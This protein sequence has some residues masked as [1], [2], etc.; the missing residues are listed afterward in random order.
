[1]R[2]PGFGSDKERGWGDRQSVARDYIHQVRA[3]LGESR[4][5]PDLANLAGRKTP[6]DAA[7]LTQFLYS[8]IVPGGKSVTH[9][10][11]KFLFEDR[12]VTGEVS[13]Q[14]L[15]IAVAAGRQIV[16]T[17][18]AQTLVAYLQSLNTPYAY[19]E[20][21]PYVPAPEKKEGHK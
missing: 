21:K 20:A 1:V 16:P 15:P 12:A 11:Y 10:P 13:A 14:A 5:G 17:E 2:R 6:Y 18:R 3:Q 9:P 8:G 19:P 7:A 4:T